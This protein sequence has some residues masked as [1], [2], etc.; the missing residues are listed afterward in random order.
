ML[1]IHRLGYITYEDRVVCNRV[2]M[3]PEITK[4][5]NEKIT[6]DLDN[7]WTITR[8]S[9]GIFLSW[10]SIPDESHPLA[11]Y[12]ENGRSWFLS[13]HNKLDGYLSF[14]KGQPNFGS[15]LKDIRTSGLNTELSWT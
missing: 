2:G 6:L 4:M 11:W 7:T 13:T 12:Y 10:Y 8:L 9:Q 5:V 3:T 1:E 15:L 14:W